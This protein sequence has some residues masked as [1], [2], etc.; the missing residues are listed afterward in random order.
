MPLKKIYIYIKEMV[1]YLG[2]GGELQLRKFWKIKG[3]WYDNKSKIFMVTGR[4]FTILISEHLC[5]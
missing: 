4:E 2:R 5:R 1:F 3:E